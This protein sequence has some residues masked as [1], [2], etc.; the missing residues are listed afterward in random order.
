MVEN[1][2]L[3]KSIFKL[4]EVSRIL[5]AP[6]NSAFGIV[7]RNKNQLNSFCKL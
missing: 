5:H 4:Y 2:I 6:T 7:M 3:K 1:V